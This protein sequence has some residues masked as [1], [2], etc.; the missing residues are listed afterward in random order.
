MDKM[1]LL[2][3]KIALVTGAGQGVG[4][5]IALALCNHGARLAL[6][7]RREGPLEE[8]RAEIE[9]RGGTAS[10]HLCDVKD[11]ARLT[12]LVAEVVAAAGGIDILVNNA[13][14]APL[15]R[16]FEVSDEDFLAGFESGPLAS[17]RLMKLCH[18]VMQARGGGV[19]INLATS[20]ATRWDSGGYGPYAAV[21]QAS[22]ALTRAAAN[23]FGPDNI[24]V[25]TM[26]PVALSPGMVS[27]SE[28]NPEAAAA[29]VA[30]VPLG[31]IGHCETD[32]GEGVAMLCSPMAQFLTGATIPLDG[33]LANF[34]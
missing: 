2:E 19:M 32:I 4:Q 21:K 28:E 34:D 3:G 15:G 29:Y 5:G 20:A 18:P 13:Q 24:R 23:E 16:L 1:R 25:L 8:T 12:E 6:V 7:G 31:R 10:V 26:A 22:R 9:R 30:T 27:W 17:F 11:G 14:D 33:G